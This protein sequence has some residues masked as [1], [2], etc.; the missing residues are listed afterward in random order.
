M[1]KE[2]DYATIE[3]VNQKLDELSHT[4]FSSV[5]A[6]ETAMNSIFTD[7]EIEFPGGLSVDEDTIYKIEGED[8]LFLYVV[9]D[10]EP[11]GYSLFAQILQQE[12]IVDIQDSI[13]VDEYS[14]GI[15]FL[16][17]VRHSADD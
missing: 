6:I 7:H 11:I 17:R 5:D 16:T 3:M 4:N 8:D 9:I 14:D 1:K 12:D 15:D 2:I 10:E 13:D